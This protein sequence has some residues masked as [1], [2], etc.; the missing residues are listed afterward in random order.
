MTELTIPPPAPIWRIAAAP[1]TAL[2]GVGRAADV[3][4]GRLV[5]LEPGHWLAVGAI[6]PNR[7]PGVAIDVSG[8]LERRRLHGAGWRARL[9]VGGWFDAEAPDFAPGCVA[10]TVMHDVPVLLDCIAADTCDIWVPRSYA[11]WFFAEWSD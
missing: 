11:E 9:M 1:D 4:G 8:A 3:G 5:C 2:P 6:D 10:R 7:F